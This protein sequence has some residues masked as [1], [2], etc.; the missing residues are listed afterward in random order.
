MKFLDGN[1]NYHV[2]IIHSQLTKNI[3]ATFKEVHEELIMAMDDSIPT[4][5]DSAWKFLSEEAISHKAR[6]VGQGPHSRH[7]STRGLPCLESYFCWSPSMFV[8]K[9]CLFDTFAA[10][11]N[12]FHPQAG[13]MTIRLYI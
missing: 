2:D 10:Y 11:P 5:E 3:A 9:F 4:C 8:I 1:D 6:R 13:I 7:P 12:F